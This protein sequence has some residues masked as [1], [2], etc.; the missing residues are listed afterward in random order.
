MASIKSIGTYLPP[1]KADL[2]ELKQIGKDWLADSP[3]NQQL[4]ARFLDSSKTANRQYF[5]PAKEILRL[6]GMQSRAALFETYGP[7]FACSSYSAA[8][9]NSNSTALSTLVFTS[10]SCP[11]IP[12]IDATM[13]DRLP[14]PRETMRIPIFQQGCAGGVVGLQLAAEL[15]RT[16]G[17]VALTS[18]EICSLVFQNAGTN[19]AQIVGAAI[20]ADGAATAIVSPTNQGLCFKAAQSYLIP[21]TRSLMGYNLLDDGFHLRLE[22]EIPAVLAEYT[23]PV[24]KEFLKK[25]GLAPKEVRHW[26]FHPGGVKILEGLEAT[27]NLKREQTWPAWKVLSEIG[28]L[29]SATVLFVLKT[30]LE[31]TSLNTGEPVILVGVGPGLTLEMILFNWQEKT[32]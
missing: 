17:D 20:F 21:N 25:N 29:S 4:F 10:C 18:V 2:S 12:S 19:R 11:V 15:S 22:R 23:A 26:L 13:I 1:H 32:L 30:F 6:A 24:V 16:R 28:N 8:T 31:N 14:L 7:E 3:E 27:L 9:S 5:M